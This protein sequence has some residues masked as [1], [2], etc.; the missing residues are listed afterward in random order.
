MSNIDYSKY[1]IKIYKHWIVSVNPNQSYL[2]RCIIWCKRK[3]ALDLPDA[4]IKEREELFIILKKL[5]KAI[6][7]NFKPAIINYSFLG[8]RTHHLHCHAIP[9]Y[10]KPFQFMN[11]KFSDKYFG[12]NYKTDEKFKTPQKILDFVIEKFKNSL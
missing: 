1:Y 11:K 6:N 2:G 8:N 3:N 4:T 10:S 12:K 7:K 5:E 9:R